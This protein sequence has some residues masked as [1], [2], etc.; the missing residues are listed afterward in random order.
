MYFP[1]NSFILKIRNF[2]QRI[3]QNNQQ[4]VLNFK[5]KT[6]KRRQLL[7]IKWFRYFRKTQNETGFSF[8]FIWGFPV[9]KIYTNIKNHDLNQKKIFFKFKRTFSFQSKIKNVQLKFFFTVFFFI[10]FFDFQMQNITLLSKVSRAEVFY[11][12]NQNCDLNFFQ[13]FNF[14]LFFLFFTQDKNIQQKWQKK[15]I[16]VQL[17][18]TKLH[19][20]YITTQTYTCISY[21]IYVTYITLTLQIYV[22][23]KPA[24]T[25]TFIPY[26]TT[27]LQKRVIYQIILQ[28]FKK[29]LQ[30]VILKN[31]NRRFLDQI[32]VY[33][34]KKT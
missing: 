16:L 7:Q 21:N 1:Q 32:Q 19:Y 4:N 14:V 10:F 33:A 28:N 31:K 8:F 23:Y 27:K 5:T 24:K 30:N 6:R 20:V 18:S 15:L 3:K 11:L 26:A 34:T 17:V 2:Q 13:F 12:I 22:L 25:Q 9:K 29:Y